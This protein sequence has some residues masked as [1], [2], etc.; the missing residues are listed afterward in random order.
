MI[1]KVN[2]SSDDLAANAKSVIKAIRDAKPEGVK[3]KYIKKCYFSTTM[4]SSV[5]LLESGYNA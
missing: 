3:G 4:G 1:G 2:F 5:E